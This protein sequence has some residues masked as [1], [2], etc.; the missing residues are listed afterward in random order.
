MIQQNGLRC[1]M[2]KLIKVIIGIILVVGL[3]V[4]GV[5]ALTS[6]RV[7]T[8]CTVTDKDRVTGTEG[9]SN[10]RVYTEQCGVLNVEDSLLDLQFNSADVFSS[11]KVGETYDFKTR[12]LRIPLMSMFPN[13]VSVTVS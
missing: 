12:G 1:N 9:K 7:E 3:F 11:I 5:V 8:S 13:I 10:M 6:L 2:D 4:P